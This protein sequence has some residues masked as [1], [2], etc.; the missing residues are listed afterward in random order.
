MHITT[1]NIINTDV[2]AVTC[3]SWHTQ[4][5]AIGYLLVHLALCAVAYPL[6]R[7]QFFLH[8]AC[9]AAYIADLSLCAL[10]IVNHRAA[11]YLRACLLVYYSP[12]LQVEY[13]DNIVHCNNVHVHA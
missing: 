4:A 2:H 6:K 1:V 7:V 12:P 10:P 8:V 13:F 9:L 11:P 5:L 3:T